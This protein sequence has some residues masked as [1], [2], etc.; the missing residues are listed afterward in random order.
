MGFAEGNMKHEKLGDSVLEKL[1]IVIPKYN[2]GGFNKLCGHLAEHL[3]ERPS[4]FFFGFDSSEIDKYKEISKNNFKEKL[5]YWECVSSESMTANLG[6]Y[7]DI[8]P[9]EKAVVLAVCG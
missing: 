7:F 6:N 3:E 4:V 5:N 9:S 1:G 8:K 2:E